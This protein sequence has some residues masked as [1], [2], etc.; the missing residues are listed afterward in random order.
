MR[1]AI[2]PETPCCFSSVLTAAFVA[3]WIRPTR[4]TTFLRLAVACDGL[5]VAGYRIEPAAN[6]LW[7]I[8]ETEGMR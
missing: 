7:R 4:V 6:A 5:N 2:E 1:L 3:Q 8:S